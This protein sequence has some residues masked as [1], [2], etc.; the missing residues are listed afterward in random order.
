M[1]SDLPKAGT[2]P[3]NNPALASVWGTFLSAA[4]RYYNAVT[5]EDR[6]NF[7]DELHGPKRTD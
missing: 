2:D 5:S 1:S 4:V 6:G 7:P 3:W